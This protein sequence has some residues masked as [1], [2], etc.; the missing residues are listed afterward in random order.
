M[1]GLIPDLLPGTDILLVAREP[2]ASSTLEQTHLALLS[3][4]RRA[5]LIKSRDAT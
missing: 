2:L 5:G 4:F 1:H 3:L